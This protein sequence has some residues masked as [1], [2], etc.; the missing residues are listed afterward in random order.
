MWRALASWAAV[1]LV[2]CAALALLAA[3]KVLR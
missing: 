2:V 3:H 1:G